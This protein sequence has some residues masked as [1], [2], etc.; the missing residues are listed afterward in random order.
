MIKI[1]EKE[2]TVEFIGPISLIDLT[3]LIK[4]YYI[5]SNYGI[6]IKDDR[7]KPSTAN[8]APSNHIDNPVNPFRY[9]RDVCY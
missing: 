3:A 5:P 9:P 6:I 1:N 8:P 2:E 7:V 4:K